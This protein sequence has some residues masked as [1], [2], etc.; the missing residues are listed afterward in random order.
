MADPWSQLESWLGER[1]LTPP[2]G[3]LGA[4]RRHWALVAEESRRHNLT[5][6][7]RTAVAVERHYLDSLAPLWSGP[8][9][10]EGPATVLDAGAGAG[11]PGIP[12]KLFR[13]AWDLTLADARLKKVRFLERVIQTLG[14]EGCRAVHARLGRASQALD[15]R[16]D[17]VLARALAEPRAALRAAERA[18]RPGGAL[19]LYTVRQDDA[20]LQTLRAEGE[21][22]SLRF[23]GQTQAA[24]PSVRDHVL[25]EFRR[26]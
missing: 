6:I 2:P 24:L 15:A 13:P 9:L 14:L 19:L 23:A 25:L 12:L 10:P 16:F 8:A 3:A 1:G 5:A 26:D 7:R 22:R 20:A 4:L 11:F 18:P 21:K 17:L